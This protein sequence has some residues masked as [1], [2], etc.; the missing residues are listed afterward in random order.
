MLVVTGDGEMLM[1]LGS[2]TA[3]GARR[4]AN[5][6]IVVLDN[7]RYGET[8]M[9]RSNTGRGTNLA[10]VAKASGVPVVA[11]VGSAARLD[12]A[13]VPRPDGARPGLRHAQDR[14]GGTRPRPAPAQRGAAEGAVPG[15]A[16]GIGRV[17][18]GQN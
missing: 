9:Q 4:P 10:A 14:A 12:E 18:F 17:E 6:A 1:G 7:E 15:G 11:T 8:G 13:V 2:L 3:V 16:G 5:L